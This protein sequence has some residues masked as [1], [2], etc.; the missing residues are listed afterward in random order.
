MIAWRAPVG[1]ALVSQVIAGAMSWLDGL[2]YSRLRLVDCLLP[3]PSAP[4]LPFGALGKWSVS[5]RSDTRVR[6]LDVC[7]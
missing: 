2:L 3:L 5:R 7:Y 4:C 6:I 1:P